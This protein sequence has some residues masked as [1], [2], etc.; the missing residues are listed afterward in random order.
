[1]VGASSN[2]FEGVVVVHLARIIPSA[3]FVVA[4]AGPSLVAGPALAGPPISDTGPEVSA[5]VHSDVSPPLRYMTPTSPSSATLRERPLR[6][7]GPAG[8]AGGPDPVV[9]ATAGTAVAT[10]PALGFAGVD[11]CAAGGGCW[12]PPDTNGA[13]GATQYVQWVN[14]AFAVYN[15]STGALV[16]GFPKAGNA[17]WA[18]F[19]GGCQANNDG[20]PIVQ[21]DKAAGRWILTQFSVSTLPYTQCVAVSTTSDATGTYSRYAFSYGNTQFNDYPKLGVWPDGYYITYNMFTNT[22]VGS[23][24]CALDRSAMLA[25]TAATQQCFQLSSS[26]PSLLPSDLDGRTAPPAG[27]PNYVMNFGSNSLNLWRFHVDWANSGNTTLSGPVNIPVASFST[28]CNGSNCIP[29]PSTSQKLDSLGDRLMYRLAYRNFGDHEALVVNHSVK[30][31]GGPLSSGVSSVRWYELR[32]P[33][34]S[35][36]AA[37][38]P[39]VYQQGTLGTADG[40]HRWMGSIA[41]DGAGNIALGYSASSGT[42]Y[43]SI[44]YTGRVPTDATG[45][46]QAETIVK[47]GTGSQL[48]NLSRWGDYSAMTIDPNDDCTFWYTSEYLKTNGTWNWSTWITSFTFPSC[49][50]APAPL[51]VSTTSLPAGTVNHAYSANLAASGGTGTY[52]WSITTGTLP[53]GLSLNATTGAIT[54]TPTTTGTSSFTATVNDGA[55]TANRSLSITVNPD[56][57]GLTITTTSLPGGTQGVA[58]PSTQLNAANGTTPYHWSIVSGALPAGLSLSTGGLVSG[59]PA[60]VGNFTFTV[61]VTDSAGSPQSATRVFTIK[62]S[63]H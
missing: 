34:G 2:S 26:Y 20:D 35:T 11:V 46:M 16:T 10:T 5:A 44:R 7:I 56:V 13:V 53:S 47:S 32:N 39:V 49:T 50:G 24:V 12:A 1:V 18:G 28:A 60:K 29:Q 48:Q 23:K 58:Y 57:T 40:I 3:L 9:Q 54:G 52:S 21:Y 15:K 4:L 6:T 33:T 59:T 17:V 27:S 51:A 14:A 62:I 55:T 8:A 36:I 41:M 37:G 30:V 38:T 45:T 31:G 25:G 61:Q 42:V 19:G 43:P 22:F 63:Q